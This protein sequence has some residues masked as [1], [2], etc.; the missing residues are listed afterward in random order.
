[1]ILDVKSSRRNNIPPPPQT[2][3]QHLEQSFQFVSCPLKP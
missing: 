2:P 1:M 3:K